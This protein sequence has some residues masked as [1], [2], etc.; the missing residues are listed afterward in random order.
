MM[1]T[2]RIVGAVT[3]AL[4]VLT[5]SAAQ[6]APA[7]EV[8]SSSGITWMNAT[9]NEATDGLRI[10]ILAPKLKGR[11]RVLWQAC[12]FGGTLPGTYRCGIDTSKGSLAQKRDGRWVAT[13]F[14]GGVRVARTSFTI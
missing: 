14:A 12:R 9:T 3:V 4:F 10:K 11:G 5:G 13:V 8:T 2:L 6:A 7:V 1:K